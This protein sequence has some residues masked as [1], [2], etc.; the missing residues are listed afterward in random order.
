MKLAVHCTPNEIIFRAPRRSHPRNQSL[1]L[2][3]RDA[4]RSTRSQAPVIHRFSGLTVESEPAVYHGQHCGERHQRSTINDGHTVLRPSRH[5]DNG[6]QT[7]LT[8]NGNEAFAPSSVPLYPVKNPRVILSSLQIH[9]SF[10]LTARSNTSTLH[11]LGD[12][13]RSVLLS[14]GCA[15][16]T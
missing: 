10:T 5:L 13:Y 16:I 8:R 15:V 2:V 11:P 9:V 7:P 14:S 1:S 12:R 3:N 4:A 6:A